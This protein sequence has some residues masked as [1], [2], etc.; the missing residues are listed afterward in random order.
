LGG[1]FSGVFRFPKPKPVELQH[2]FNTTC[3]IGKPV[4]EPQRV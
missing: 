2:D 1:K 4:I 3:A